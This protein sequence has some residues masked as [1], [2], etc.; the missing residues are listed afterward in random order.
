M[1]TRKRVWALFLLAGLLL[2]GCVS[3][4]PV[5]ETKPAAKEPVPE[6]TSAVKPEPEPIWEPPA[7]PKPVEAVKEAAPN[8]PQPQKAETPADELKAWIGKWPQEYRVQY[9]ITS[10]FG[11]QIAEMLEAEYFKTDKRRIDL[12]VDDGTHFTNTRT[13]YLPDQTVVCNSLDGEAEFCMKTGKEEARTDFTQLEQ[14]DFASYTIT[15]EEPQRIAGDQTNCYKLVRAEDGSETTVC[16]TFDG[17]P[18]YLSTLGKQDG[19]DVA[20]TV[21]AE[22]LERRVPDN[23][24][25]APSAQS[26]EE[27]G[28]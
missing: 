12:F 10:F 2:A 4:N 9:K 15:R 28:G 8:W 23:E 7:K 17:I 25:E 3:Q 6:A 14:A 24:L 22:S 5:V 13:F 11:E 21:E 20:T 16:Y 27:L 1:D 19:V 26:L 18:L